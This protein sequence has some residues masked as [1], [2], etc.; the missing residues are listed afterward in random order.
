MNYRHDIYGR[1]VFDGDRSY[2]YGEN[3]RPQSDL[4]RRCDELERE[5]QAAEQHNEIVEWSLIRDLVKAWEQEFMYADSHGEANQSTED[6]AVRSA[7]D[8]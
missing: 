6:L 2:W 4:S 5:Q 7:W 8:W 3:V 1:T